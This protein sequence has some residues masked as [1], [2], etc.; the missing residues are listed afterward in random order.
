MLKVIEEPQENTEILRSDEAHE[1]FWL[2]RTDNIDF[3]DNSRNRIFQLN[4]SALKQD[5]T[6]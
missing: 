6:H 5:A 4:T 2:L 3:A 1:R